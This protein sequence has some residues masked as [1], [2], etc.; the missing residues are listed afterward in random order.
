MP[1]DDDD[2]WELSAVKRVSAIGNAVLAAGRAADARVEDLQRKELESSGAGSA[3]EG[4]RSVT[5]TA[6]DDDDAW[7][8]RRV[9]APAR[10][11][12]M[13]PAPTMALMVLDG[14]SDGLEAFETSLSKARNHVICASGGIECVL[15]LECVLL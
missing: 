13:P 10:A 3:P 5:T 7:D 15:L 9:L 8:H 6:L 2:D 11:V 14:S 12:S 4:H 1:D